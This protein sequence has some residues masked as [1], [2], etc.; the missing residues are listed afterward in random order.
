MNNSPSSPPWWRPDI[1]ARRKPFLDARGKALRALRS[2]FEGE[3][4]AEVE[5]P[6]LQISPGNETHLHAFK[7]EFADP[8]SGKRQDYYL[9][10]SP[11]FSMKKLLVAGM[12]KIFQLSHVF[13][14]GEFSPR[15]HPEFSMLEWYRAGARLDAIKQDCIALVRAA[16]KAAGIE[17]FSAQGMVCDPFAEWES[18]TVPD[19]FR[20]YADMDLM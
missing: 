7:T 3:G 15:H 11:E 14:N 12:P 16:A 17:K 4:F 2:Y 19:A 10:T 18:V 5:T 9:H 20:R 6:S 13:R 8:F 1:F